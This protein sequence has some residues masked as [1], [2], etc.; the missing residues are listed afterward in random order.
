MLEN[1]KVGVLEYEIVE[2]FLTDLKRK[3]GGEKKKQS[4]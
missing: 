1:L 3:L 2:E 4:K